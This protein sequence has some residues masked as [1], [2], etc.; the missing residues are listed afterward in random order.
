MGQ[1]DD[2]STVPLT[3]VLEKE[4]RYTEINPKNPLLK[5]EHSVRRIG[6][7]M[8]H[9]AQLRIACDERAFWSA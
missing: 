8:Y 1:R 7:V 5:T 4:I 3:V 9:I 6:G 2:L